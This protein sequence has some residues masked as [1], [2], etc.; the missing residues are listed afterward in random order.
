MARNQPT[1]T[2]YSS[3]EAGFWCVTIALMLA[4]LLIFSTLYVFQPLLPVFVQEFKISATESSFLMSAAVISMAV[5]LF[6]LGFLSDRYGRLRLMQLSLVI[7]VVLLIAMP[8]SSSFE[9]LVALRLLQ[10]FFLAGIPAAAMGYLGEEVSSN[11]LGLA[12]TLYISSNAFGGMGGRVVGGYLTGVF[13]WESMLFILAGVG[14]IAMIL[15]IWLLPKERFFEKVDQSLKED[16]RG[17]IVHLKDRSMLVLFMVGLL[18]QIV[19]TAVWT[20]L[21]F[22]L[23][24]DPYNW[25][26]KWIS[27]TYFAYILGVL[28]PP[29]AGKLSDSL[30]QTKMMFAGLLIL[31]GGVV[32]TLF[33]PVGF[34]LAGLALLCSGFF[35][36]HSMAAALVSKS[37]TH[38]RSGASGFY[39]ISY[40]TGVAIGS[41]AVGAL[42]E[43]YQWIGVVAT[44]LVL[45]FIFIC[46]P[47]F[48]K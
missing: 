28:A 44:S 12:M 37:A 24:S 46:F 39:L 7:T 3:R 34:I 33:S 32:L 38:H 40:Y 36:A 15:F 45:V 35:V 8:F 17:M 6:V 18:L 29:F 27:I 26:L 1:M 25:S 10:G 19:F 42:W 13:Q 5:G 48:K 41:T 30:G 9:W 22:Y 47:L 23:Q 43:N 2:P 21:P 4:S 31:I 14:V 16:L 11:H 20:Y